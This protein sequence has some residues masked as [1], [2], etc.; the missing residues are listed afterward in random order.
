MAS[1][2]LNTEVDIDNSKGL[3]LPGAYV[4][5]H[6][7]LPGQIHSV[8]IPSDTLLFR[9][10]GLQ[11][12]VVRNNVAQL[13]PVT[14]GTDYGESVQV[15]SGLDTSDDVIESP[16]DSLVSGTPVRIARGASGDDQ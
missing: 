5:V 13:V 4:Q 11:V 7:A 2:T 12:G 9:T 16:S 1:R 8:V 6:L 15:T 3:L 14:I 10:Q